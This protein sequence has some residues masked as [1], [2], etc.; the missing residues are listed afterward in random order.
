MSQ[1]GVREAVS[2]TLA[3]FVIWG[4]EVAFLV[5]LSLLSCKLGTMGSFSIL[6]SCWEVRKEKK[7]PK[8]CLKARANPSALQAF[9]ECQFWC[10]TS[11]P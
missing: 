6:M 9:L 3:S 1:A 4:K 5:D 11:L 7:P 2:P 8:S 10:F